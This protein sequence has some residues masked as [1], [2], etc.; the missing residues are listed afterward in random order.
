MPRNETQVRE[1]EADQL[2][3]R[4][5]GIAYARAAG[6]AVGLFLILWSPFNLLRWGGQGPSALLNFAFIFFIAYGILLAMPWQRLRSERVFR[7]FFGILIV[8]SI[9]FG[10]LM[11]VDLIFQYM[12]AAEFANKPAPPAFQ[13]MLV[14]AA[15]MQVPV[16]LFARRPGL[17]G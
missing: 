17:L 4:L 16:V 7:F 6:V 3:K 14:F 5:K 15:L 12:L 10:F 11:V 2:D 8:F 13:G 9:A 1:L